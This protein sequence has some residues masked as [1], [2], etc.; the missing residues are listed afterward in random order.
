M[1]CAILSFENRRSGN[2]F[3]AGKVAVHENLSHVGVAPDGSLLLAGVFNNLVRII[4]DLDHF[5]EDLEH[6]GG[7]D[8]IG[9]SAFHE[10][11]LS[12]FH[13]LEVMEVNIVDIERVRSINRHLG[14]LNEFFKPRHTVGLDCRVF[15]LVHA[16]GAKATHVI[17][18]R[19]FG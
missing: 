10:V 11:D 7:F 2:R 1:S 15:D 12:I 13:E 8:L 14:R 17:V 4:L 6:S 19:L 9:V 5:V 18:A 3:L 16:C